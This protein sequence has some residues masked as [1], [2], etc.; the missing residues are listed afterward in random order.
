MIVPEGIKGVQRA[1]G[2]GLLPHITHCLYYQTNMPDDIEISRPYERALGTL[3][4]EH[5]GAGT[6]GQVSLPGA[7]S[8][9]FASSAKLRSRDSR[10]RKRQRPS[11]SSRTMSNFQVQDAAVSNLIWCLNPRISPSK[12]KDR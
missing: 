5:R 2:G 4:D 11:E 12:Y 1:A 6:E 9:T 3:G 7:S 10:R 8:A